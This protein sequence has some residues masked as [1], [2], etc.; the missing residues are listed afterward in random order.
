MGTTASQPRRLA[1]ITEAAEYVGC[2]KDTIR[3]MIVGGD[4]PGYR[5]GSKLLRVDLDD[6]DA[7]LHPVGIAAS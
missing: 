6:L 7:A 4:L 2:S 1:S 5:L 3:R